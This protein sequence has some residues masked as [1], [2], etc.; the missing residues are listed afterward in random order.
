M[1]RREFLGTLGVGLAGVAMNG[2]WG[3][4]TKPPG[5]PNIIFMMTDDQGYSELS[6]YGSPNIKTPNLDRMAA[7]GVRFT[8]YYAAGSVCTP[9]R[10]SLMTGCYPKRVGLHKGVLGT[11]DKRGLHPDEVTIA[12]LLRDQGYATA[13]IGKWHLGVA[14]ET[15]P[16]SQG[17]DSYFGMPGDN[18]GHG[19]LYRGTNII[20]QEGKINISEL[21]QRYTTEAIEFITKSKGKPFFLYLP[22]GAPHAPY[23]ASENFRKKSA[24][25]LRG[26]MIEE[27]DWSV[28]Q[29]LQTLKDLNL[30]EKTLVIY[31]SDNGKPG[32]QPPLR[33]SKGTTWEG[34]MRVA[35]I[36]RWPGHVPTNTVC[37]QM[38]ISFDWLPTLAALAGTAPPA[39]RKIDGKDI[40]P[41]M[42][43]KAKT[44]HDY[45]VYYDTGGKASA[46]R[47]GKWK[48][49]VQPGASGKPTASTGLYD[50][51]TDLGETQ[52]V[53]SAHAD[54]VK[55]LV[56]KLQQ[57]DKM[58]TQEARPVFAAQP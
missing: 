12:E 38:A 55:L 43:G 46:I 10:A 36:A 14:P 11:R 6:C 17:F 35:C 21:T 40:W 19:E 26:D 39:D 44:P 32:Q 9:T 22:H 5:K 2:V 58:L 53:A 34:G 51:E 7:E 8:D 27:V 3:A 13:C 57:T 50:L 25:G 49:H 33:G 48:L 16:T 31:T 29:V 30:D 56:E 15:M 18:H 52:D 41:V 23:Y 1:H 37:N 47:S 28:G 20:E 54:V 4:E 45:F 42:C 24:A